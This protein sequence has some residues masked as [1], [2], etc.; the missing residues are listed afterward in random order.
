ME[1]DLKVSGVEL[2][3]G[4]AEYRNG[5]LFI[6]KEVINLREQDLIKEKHKPSSELVVEW[7]PLQ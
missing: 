5:G 1:A 3:T 6:D 2:L 4:L 7:R